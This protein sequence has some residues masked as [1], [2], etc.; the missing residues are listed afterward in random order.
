MKIII[1][2]EWTLN[3]ITMAMKT[4]MLSM[5]DNATEDLN[6]N[7]SANDDLNTNYNANDN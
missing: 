7:L 5:N 1:T 3:I 2:R 6:E 4:L